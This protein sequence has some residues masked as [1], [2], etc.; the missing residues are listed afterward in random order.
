LLS[1]DRA[2]DIA[3]LGNVGEINLG[4]DF[5]GINPAGTRSPPSSLGF[6]VS[7]EVG[8]D[9]GCLMLFQRTGMG[10][11]LGDPDFHK[12]VEDRLAL[13]FQLSRQIVDSNLAHPPFLSSARSR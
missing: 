10:L 9:L 4:L 12:H 5:V 2:Q 11:L 1:A 13:D 6:T 7:L 3:W 8:P